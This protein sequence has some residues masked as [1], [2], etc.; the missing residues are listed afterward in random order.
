MAELLTVRDVAALVKLSSR[1]IYKLAASGRMP[2]PLKVSRST[3]WRAADIEK[4]IQNGCRIE[5]DAKAVRR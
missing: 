3:R 4:W 1:Q 5:A 2:L